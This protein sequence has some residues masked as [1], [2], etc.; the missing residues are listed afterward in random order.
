MK[1]IK[2]LL[3]LITF[4]SFALLYSSCKEEEKVFDG[5]PIV[6]FESGS[7]YINVE[8]TNPEFNIEVMLV[9]P[10]YSSSKNVSF[11]V[12]DEYET[13]SGTTISTTVQA[14]K[15]YKEFSSNTITFSPKSSIA[16]LPIEFNFEEL[17]RDSI[18]RMVLELQEGDVGVSEKAN[19]VCV[20]TLTPHKVFVPEDFTGQFNATHISNFGTEEFPVIIELDSVH[21]NGRIFYLSIDGVFQGWLTENLGE[22]RDLQKINLVVDDRDPAKSNVTADKQYFMT[23]GP[24]EINW[25]PRTGL[26]SFDTWE[27][28]FTIPTYD[29]KKASGA[30]AF[31]SGPLL[32]KDTNVRVLL[33]FE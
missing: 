10:Q 32:N 28:S 17:V 15:E 8:H 13:A 16:N 12:L 29:L 21:S 11:R 2:L 19:Q 14:N 31:T 33:I 3:T 26:G 18:Y 1:E 24:D 22:T 9:G 30:A 5:E 20:V 4:L 6:A 23:I 25:E 7:H 27:K